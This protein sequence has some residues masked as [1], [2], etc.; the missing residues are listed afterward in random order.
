MTNHPET[1]TERQRRVW[2]LHQAGMSQRAIALHL[3]IS[4]ATVRDHLEAADARI[5]QHQEQDQ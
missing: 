1:L 2:E 3:R 5:H 4:R